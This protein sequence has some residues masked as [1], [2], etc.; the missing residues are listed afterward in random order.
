MLFSTSIAGS[1]DNTKIYN[2]SFNSQPLSFFVVHNLLKIE[3]E[4]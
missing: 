3:A 1:T 2:C 4:L